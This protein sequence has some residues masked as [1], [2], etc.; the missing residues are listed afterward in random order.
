[1]QRFPDKA[2][3]GALVLSFNLGAALE[4]EEKLSGTPTVKVTSISGSDSQVRG[5]WVGEPQLDP[6]ASAVLV[7]IASGIDMNDYAVEVQCE[8]TAD[9][10]LSM[11]GILPVRLYPQILV[12]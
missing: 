4:G 3:F 2:P 10:T 11:S 12:P 7:P 5:L 1:M 6:A 8:S 9:K